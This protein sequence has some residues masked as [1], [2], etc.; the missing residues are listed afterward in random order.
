MKILELSEFPDH[1]KTLKPK[2]WKPLIDLIPIVESTKVLYGLAEQ[3]EIEKGVFEFPHNE[4]A[5]VVSKFIQISYDMGIV[6]DFRWMEWDEGRELASGDIANIYK[7][8]LTT[9]CKLITANIRSDRFCDGAM[10]EFF[11]CGLGLAIL[12]RIEEIVMKENE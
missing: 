2:D 7:Q 3:K 6:I 9:L 8:D 4:K 11:Q 10:G 12:K 5:R 1:L